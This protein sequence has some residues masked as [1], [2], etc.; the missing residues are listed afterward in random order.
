MPKFPTDISIKAFN[1]QNG[2]CGLCK[3]RLTYGNYE[4]GD[5]GAWHA[6]HINGNNTDHRLSNCVC[7]CI[8]EPK[9]CHLEAHHCNFAGDYV[10]PKNSFYLNG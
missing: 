8:N 5:K 3:K 4:K 10:I 7:L 2:L 6:H 1:R 9:N